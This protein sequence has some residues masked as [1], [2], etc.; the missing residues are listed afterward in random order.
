M[1]T[2]CTSRRLPCRISANCTYLSSVKLVG[3]AKYLYG[4]TPSAGTPY[5]AGIESTTSGLPICQPSVYFGLGGKSFG[6]PSFA[7]SSTQA[8]TV[9]ISFC[10][11]RGLLENS[12]CAGSANQGGIARVT[13][14]SRM[15]L[16]Q[17]RTSL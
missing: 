15:A 17:G 10:E 14:F 6:S 11:R 7:P 2:W 5:S 3:T 9:S 8:A 12:P 1:I 16:A 4:I 13:T